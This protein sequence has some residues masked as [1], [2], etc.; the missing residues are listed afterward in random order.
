M[1]LQT[2]F[3]NDIE[4]Y[5][6]SKLPELPEYIAMEIGAYIGNRVGIFVSDMYYQNEER[7]EKRMKRTTRN[8]VKMND[9][10]KNDKE[11]DD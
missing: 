4:R 1:S 9:Q 6:N 5:L 8:N 10:Y 2:E 11:S 7:N 3:L